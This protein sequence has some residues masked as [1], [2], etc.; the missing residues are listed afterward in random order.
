MGP[1]ACGKTD[2]AIKLVQTLPCEIV[3]VDSAMVYK[4]MN[5][6][7]AKPSAEELALAPHHLINLCDPAE[8]YSVGR[9][10]EDAHR[11]ISSIHAQN[12]I[13]LLTGGSMLYFHQLQ[14]GFN[15]MPK[16]D[17]EVRDRITLQAREN[18]WPSMHAE[19][20]KIDPATAEQLHPNDAQ[21]ISRALE[22][23]YSTGK[24]LHYWI[25]NQNLQPLQNKTLNFILA[26][27]ERSIL[28]ERIAKR[29]GIMLQQGFENEVKKLYAR[30]DLSLELPSI[31]SVGYRQMWSYLEG[32]YDYDTMRERAVIATRQ[33]AKRQM[34]WLRRWKEA[35]WVDSLSSGAF[36]I[37]INAV[38]NNE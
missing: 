13:P 19:L 30:G 35:Q 37:I 6:G 15:D 23:F 9:F 3:S 10:C 26:P 18:G 11:V 16:T 8:S 17:P 33:L 5:I 24:T 31:R 20:E 28:H 1:T 12:K 2:V 36:D 25:N 14:Q 4:E 7:T 22:V 34:T 38:N 21:R 29:F 32:D 27:S